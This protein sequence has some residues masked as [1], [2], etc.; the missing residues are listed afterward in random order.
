MALVCSCLNRERGREVRGIQRKQRK[1]EEGDGRE[2]DDLTGG[3]SGGL[4]GRRCALLLGTEDGGGYRDGAVRAVMQR[5]AACGTSFCGASPATGLAG[6]KRSKGGKAWRR[7]AAEA[8]A[9]L[10]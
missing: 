3:C 2:R 4:A 6:S 8:C 7:P 1:R 5:G 10:R 9:G